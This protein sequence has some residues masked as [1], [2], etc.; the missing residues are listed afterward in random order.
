MADRAPRL[1]AHAD[2]LLGEPAP[3]RMSASTRPAEVSR[4]GY[5][6]P[7]SDAGGASTPGTP[8]SSTC[9]GDQGLLGQQP[10]RTSTTVVDWLS[11]RSPGFREAIWFV[12]IDPAAPYAAA[13]R[14]PAC[15]QR[16]RSW[17]TTFMPRSGLCRCRWG[18]LLVT[19]END[20]GEVGITRVR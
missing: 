11:Q 14:S 15:A 5:T 19:A 18:L 8:G 13:I 4:A 7:P 16:H 20:A 3:V 2:G 1:I 12:A 9:P 17:S 6:A 10:G